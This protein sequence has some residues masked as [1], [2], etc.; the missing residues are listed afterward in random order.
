MRCAISWS[1]PTSNPSTWSS[2]A[3]PPNRTTSATRTTPNA[4]VDTVDWTTSRSSSSSRSSSA[5][6]AARSQAQR[7]SNAARAS[8]RRLRHVFSAASAAADWARRA[9]LRAMRRG[10]G[11][12]ACAASTI[13]A[14]LIMP[15]SWH[16]ASYRPRCASTGADPGTRPRSELPADCR[17]TKMQQCDSSNAKGG[18]EPSL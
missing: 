4:V 15:A 12:S 11:T 1:A 3:R 17:D 10:G 9:G 16:C 6:A 14:A 8:R 7:A 18:G 2:A 13:N 5:C